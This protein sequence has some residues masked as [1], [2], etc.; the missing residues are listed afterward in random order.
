V[1]PIIDARLAGGTWPPATTDSRRR[2]GN[3]AEE[4]AEQETRDEKSERKI[5]RDLEDSFPASDP[6]GWTLGVERED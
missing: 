1:K 5:D 3:R 6:P 2:E 4:K